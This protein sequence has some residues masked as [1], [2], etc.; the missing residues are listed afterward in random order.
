MNPD[1][2]NTMVDKTRTP[3]DVGLSDEEKADLEKLITGLKQDPS[4]A[5]PGASPEELQK[6]VQSMMENLTQLVEMLLKFDTK[7]R[8]LYDIVRLSYQK[9]DMM[10]KRIDAIIESVRGGKNVSPGS[11]S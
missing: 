6:Q 8:A 1:L 3:I 10:N 5:Q 9:S 2:G 7:M 11:E 4:E